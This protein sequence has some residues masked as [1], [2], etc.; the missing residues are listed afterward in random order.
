MLRGVAMGLGVQYASLTGDLSSVS[1]SAL[2]HGALDE[3][4]RYRELQQWIVDQLLEPVY[5]RWLEEAML[6]DAIV[7]PNGSSLPVRKM[8]KFREVLWQPRRWQWVDPKNEAD[9]ALKEKNNFLVSPNQLIRERGGDPVETYRDIKRSID[10]M[11]Q[12]GLSE[13]H[14]TAA[15]LGKIGSVYDTTSGETEPDSVDEDDSDDENEGTP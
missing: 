3:R 6:R 13:E 10:Q 15:I 4:A 12:A 14:I 9:A 2:R 11:K 5:Q 8:R 7:L 1:F